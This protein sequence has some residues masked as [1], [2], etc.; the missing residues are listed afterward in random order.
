MSKNGVGSGSGERRCHPCDTKS[1]PDR[2]APPA[3]SARSFARPGVNPAL[4]RGS[5]ISAASRLLIAGAQVVGFQFKG[6]S[7]EPI[8]QFVRIGK[9][10]S[11]L[12]AGDSMNGEFAIS[13][14]SLDG[15]LGVVQ[16]DCYL[17]PGDKCLHQFRVID[18]RRSH[19][20]FHRAGGPAGGWG[21]CRRNH[22]CARSSCPVRPKPLKNPK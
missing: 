16:K 18:P 22:T 2:V 11:A 9:H 5:G 15:A 19:G 3:V 4:A 8:L 6:L 7:L 17:L 12:A 20:H 21:P 14:P 10:P 1:E 13:F